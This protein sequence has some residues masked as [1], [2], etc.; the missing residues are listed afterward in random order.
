VLLLVTGAAVA[1]GL[2]SYSAILVA[3]TRSAAA[4]RQGSWSAATSTSS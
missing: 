1:L 4:D 3:S 2:L